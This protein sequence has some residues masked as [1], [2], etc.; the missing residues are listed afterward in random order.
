MM[1]VKKM[2]KEEMWNAFDRAEEIVDNGGVLSQEEWMM[3]CKIMAE[4]GFGGFGR[5]A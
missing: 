3:V 5:R 2:T 4:L 1:D